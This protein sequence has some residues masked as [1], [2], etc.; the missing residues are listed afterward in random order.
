MPYKDPERKRQWE[1]EHR[2]Q[3][4]ARRRTPRV[5]VSPIG[6]GFETTMPGPITDDRSDSSANLI[7]VLVIGFTFLVIL[8]VAGWRFFG[9]LEPGGHT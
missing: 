5:A 3:R 2:E 8:L 1:Q 9:I 6:P 7:P 4:N